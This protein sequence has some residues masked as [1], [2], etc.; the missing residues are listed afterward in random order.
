MVTVFSRTAALLLIEDF[1]HDDFMIRFPQNFH[2][3]Q[4]NNNRKRNTLY[5]TDDAVL[6]YSIY[7][8]ISQNNIDY[9]FL[10]CFSLA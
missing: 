7:Q 3:E 8:T 6:T 1:Q 10:L 5:N 9:L 4:M 2:V